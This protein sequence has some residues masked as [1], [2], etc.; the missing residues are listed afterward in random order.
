[1]FRR[2][3]E[4]APANGDDGREQPAQRIGTTDE[5]ANVVLFA[6]AAESSA[7]TASALVADY[8]NTARGGPTWPSPHYWTV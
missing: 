4:V 5:I 3:H 8:G 7:M 6:A 2:N 1:M